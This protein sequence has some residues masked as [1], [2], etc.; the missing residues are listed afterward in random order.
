MHPSL[1]VRVIKPSA[2]GA[3]CFMDRSTN[4]SL[5]NIIEEIDGIVYE[6][7]WRDVFGYE[8]IYKISS[9]G[10]VKALKRTTSQNKVLPENIK[11]QGNDK[12]GYKNILCCKKG[13]TSTLRV[14][15]MVCTAFY[16]IDNNSPVVN[17]K[18][19][20]KHDNF[21]KNLEWST[22]S[23][24]TKHAYDNNRIINYNTGRFGE[25]SI[26]SKKVNQYD[27]C[28][29][30]LNTFGGIRDAAR[31]TGINRNKINKSLKGGIKKSDKY[32]WEYA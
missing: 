10:R 21:Y 6:E 19:C 15:R 31:I 2:V 8:G 23:K 22:V 11:A 12:D 13:K 7:E 24:N 5:E 29:K 32:K 26:F 27:L 14:H 1:V 4:F 30:L 17:H 9:F 16:G 28:G 25:L 20:I 3:F 18:N